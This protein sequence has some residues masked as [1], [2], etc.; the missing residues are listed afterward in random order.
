MNEGS[1]A[2]IRA[3]E[4]GCYLVAIYRFHR[5][6]GV[7]GD[8]VTGGRRTTLLNACGVSVCSQNVV[9]R[10]ELVGGHEKRLKEMTWNCWS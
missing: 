5:W 4:S 2:V 3:N 1:Q 8:S 10:S 9:I 7:G 6:T